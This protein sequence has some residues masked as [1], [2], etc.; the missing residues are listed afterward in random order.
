MALAG[1]RV[2]DDGMLELLEP[3]RGHRHRL[4]R[5]LEVSGVGYERRAPRMA[6][7]AHRTR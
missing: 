6:I 1:Q 7:P 5:Y 2:D 3:W 4:V